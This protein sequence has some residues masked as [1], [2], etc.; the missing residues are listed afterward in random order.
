MEPNTSN[1]ASHSGT[2]Y[3]NSRLAAVDVSADQNSTAHILLNVPQRPCLVPYPARRAPSPLAHF[4]HF[5]ISSFSVKIPHCLVPPRA[6]YSFFFFFFSDIFGLPEVSR[7][8]WSCARSFLVFA[9]LLLRLFPPPDPPAS[10]V[11]P[12]LPLLLVPLLLVP[13]S[14]P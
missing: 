8:E 4:F 5:A 6:S 3:Q 9:L 13:R 2:H 10:L 14:F 7:C 11:S 12:P 1:R